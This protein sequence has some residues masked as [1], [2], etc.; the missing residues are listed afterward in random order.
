MLNCI[1][2]TECYSTCAR[3]SDECCTQFII[4]EF[5][6]FIGGGELE[7]D[8]DD[9]VF[10]LS[11]YSWYSSALLSIFLYCFMF[12][13]SYAFVVYSFSGNQHFGWKK[14]IFS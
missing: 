4:L 1:V 11:F 12:L 5:E 6:G 10:C 13:L 3:S 7:K 2:L 8:T 14:N 9:I